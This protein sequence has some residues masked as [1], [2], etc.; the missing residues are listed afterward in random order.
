[1]I[2]TILLTILGIIIVLALGVVLYLQHPIWGAKPSGERLARIESSPNYKDGAFQNIHPVEVMVQSD[3]DSPSMVTALYRFFFEKDPNSIP[4]YVPTATSKVD[5]KNLDP[6]DNIIVWMGHSSVFMQ[7]DGR[8]ILMDPVLSGYGAPVPFVNRA[9]NNTDQYS[10]ADIPDLDIL[11]ISH[12]HYDHL[13]Y[14]TVKALIPKT[15]KIVTS[16][17]VG[18]HLERW[19]ARPEQIWEGDWYNTYSDGDFSIHVLPT[20]H[21]SGRDLNRNQTLWSSFAFITPNHKIFFGADGGYSPEYKVSGDKYGPFDLA[22]LENGQYNEAWKA[23]HAM[24][25]ETAV[26]GEDLKAKRV[27]PIHNSKFKLAHHEWT[28]PMDRLI[29]AAQGKNYIVVTPMIGEGL[30]IDSSDITTHMWWK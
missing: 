13:D 6:K 26:I 12:D 27:M 25:E 9:F 29:A 1:M 16:L 24:P 21:F 5:L 3:E 17:G 7:I 8:K 14:E 11:L 30:N 22:I 18:A 23:I 10:V 19:G 15:K 20:Q 4:D 28:D 2:K